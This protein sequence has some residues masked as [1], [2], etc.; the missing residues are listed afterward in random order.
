MTTEEKLAAS[1]ATLEAAHAD[2][3]AAQE[4]EDIQECLHAY[5]DAAIAHE[6]AIE[7]ARVTDAAETTAGDDW[8]DH[9]E[10]QH[11]HADPPAIG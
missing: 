9:L 7:V 8:E 3:L 4:T 2:L 10:W 6:Y 5:R 1:L 11:F